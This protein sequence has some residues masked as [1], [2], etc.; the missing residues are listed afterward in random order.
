MDISIS[1]SSAGTF[2]RIS[3]SVLEK[4]KPI[5][6]E[7]SAIVTSPSGRDEIFLPSPEK[8]LANV[9]YPYSGGR[10]VTHTGPGKYQIIFQPKEKGSHKLKLV[11]RI[12]DRR[13]CQNEGDKSRLP[14]H[15]RLQSSTGKPFQKELQ[16]SFD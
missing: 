9:T 4:S 8:I 5:E 12:C 14:T 6:C 16:I 10:F 15:R 2:R 11:G 7:L 3:L 1:V 13:R